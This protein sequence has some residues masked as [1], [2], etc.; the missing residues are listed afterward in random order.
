MP[1]PSRNSSTSRGIGAAP[2][3]ASS[4]RPPKSWRTLPSTSRSASAYCAFSAADAVPLRIAGRALRPVAIAHANSRCLTALPSLPRAS[5]RAWIFSNTR[6]TDGKW[7]G[8]AAPTSST[9]RLESP[10]QKASVPPTSSETICTTR[11]SAWA[12]GRNMKSTAPGFRPTCR[13]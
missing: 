10:L 3:S 1:Q 5:T 9:S 8:A 4:S 12:S 13:R 2:V 7:V 6:G 11:A